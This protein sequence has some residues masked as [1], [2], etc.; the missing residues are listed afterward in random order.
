MADVNPWI[1]VIDSAI[2]IGLGSL[3]TAVAGFITLKF[4]QSREKEKEDKDL[5]YKIQEE[6][7]NVYIKFI[8]LARELD[9]RYIGITCDLDSEILHNFTKAFVEVN[10]LSGEEIRDSAKK[11]LQGV[12][13]CSFKSSPNRE[14]YRQHSI[15][16]KELEILASKEINKK[17]KR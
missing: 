1:S 9:I 13:E 2:K 6:K 3:I 10:L 16:M 15:N 14:V 8:G 4:N 11:V 17:Y 5:F 12:M 7:K